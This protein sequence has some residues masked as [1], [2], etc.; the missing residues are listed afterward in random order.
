MNTRINTASI[1]TLLFAGIVGTC[2]AL[3]QASAFAAPDKAPDPA[4]Q[5]RMTKRMEERW[6]DRMSDL[7]ADLKITAAQEPAWNAYKTAMQPPVPEKRDDMKREDWAKLTTPERL[8]KERALRQ[9]FAADADKRDDAIRA[10]YKQLSAEQ[11]K[12][13]DGKRPVPF[14]FGEGGPRGFHHGERD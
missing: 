1:K 12:T 2:L 3:A 8:D 14:F 7:K 9:Q 11:K 4:R 13:F 5:E 6:N 10:F